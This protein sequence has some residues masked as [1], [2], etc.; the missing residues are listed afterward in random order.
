MTKPTPRKAKR[1]PRK[2]V[3]ECEGVMGGGMPK[4]WTKFADKHLGKLCRVRVEVLRASSRAK[5]GG[6]K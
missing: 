6:R 3:Y 5:K 4:N 1:K 2:I